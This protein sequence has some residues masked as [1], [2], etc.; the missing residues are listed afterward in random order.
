R[1]TYAEIEDLL[2][3]EAVAQA[4]PRLL[5]AGLF[6]VTRTPSGERRYGY[7]PLV[8]RAVADVLRED[9][10][11]RYRL[12]HRRTAALRLE[13]GD[14]PE[15]FAHAVE[16]ED[17]DM[18]ATVAESWWT[19]LLAGHGD[20]LRTGLDAM[21]EHIVLASARLLVARDYILDEHTPQRA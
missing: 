21:P 17:W 3:R 20:L 15:A 19:E 13:S 4:F 9:D 5:H 14:G 1:F 12:L 6:D 11:E 2:G 8:R 10:P 7:T 16:G 18:A